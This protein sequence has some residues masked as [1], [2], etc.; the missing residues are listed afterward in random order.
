MEESSQESEVRSQNERDQGDARGSH[1]LGDP[2][3]NSDDTT[4]NADELRGAIRE[5]LQE[6]MAGKTELGEEQKRRESLEKRVNELI[7]E[8]HKTRAAAEEAQRSESI[9]TELQKL[10]VSKIELAY[11]AVKDDVYRNEDGRLLGQGGEELRDFLA[12]FVSENPELLPARL[13]GGSGANATR[14]IPASAEGIEL[15][16]IRPGMSAEEMDRVRREVL[17]VAS[18]TLKGW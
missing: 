17:R 6:F 12:T 7:A 11:R 8:N 10:G 5:V 9:R 1:G 15:A 18:R 16:S 2:P 3:H 14:R 13:S 4:H